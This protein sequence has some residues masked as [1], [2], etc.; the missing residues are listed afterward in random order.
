MEPE[1]S[2]RYMVTSKLFFA[3]HKTSTESEKSTQLRG[4]RGHVKSVSALCACV[5]ICG[6]SLCIRI[7]CQRD[8]GRKNLVYVGM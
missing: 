1:R 4:G 6:M 3:P 8:G 7:L 2:G 5:R